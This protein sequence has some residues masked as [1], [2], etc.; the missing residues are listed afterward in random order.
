MAE[1]GGQRSG[2]EQEQVWQH[3]DGPGAGTQGTGNGTLTPEAVAETQEPFLR[4]S[5]PSYSAPEA[6]EAKKTV[7]DRVSPPQMPR[8]LW[9]ERERE[10]T[11]KALR[12]QSDRAVGD[13]H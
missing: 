12:P 1:G 6:G 13:S 2:P 7:T 8:G 10:E 4:R 3:Q 11:L 9:R 5:Q